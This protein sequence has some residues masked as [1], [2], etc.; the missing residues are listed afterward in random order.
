VIPEW[1]EAHNQARS[2][3]IANWDF[4]SGVGAAPRFCRSWFADALGVSQQGGQRPL[5]V[6]EKA[7][8]GVG[9]EDEP[10]S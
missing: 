7:K 1:L 2:R 10:G 8:R 4:G 6:Q 5:L 3:T 9:E